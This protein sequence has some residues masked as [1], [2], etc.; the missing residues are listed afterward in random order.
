M[1]CV[2]N[3]QQHALAIFSPLMIPKTQFLNSLCGEK[4]CAHLI[5]L[6]L[7]RGSVLKSVQF[8][9]QPRKPAIKVQEVGADRILPAEFEAGESAGF[10]RAP[11]LCFLFGLLTSQSPRILDGVH[12]AEDKQRPTINKPLSLPSPR[13]S[14]AGRGDLVRN[15]RVQRD[16]LFSL[17]PRRR[18]GERV[19]ERGS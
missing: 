11:E 10:Q 15:S 1:K 19:G 12:E 18:S 14:L 5:A 17:A 2:P 16:S 4:F 13:S 7:A 9:A 6:K 8:N 3:F